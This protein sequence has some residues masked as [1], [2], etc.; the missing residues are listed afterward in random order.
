M[1]QKNAYLI[2]MIFLNLA[3]FGQRNLVQNGYRWR[4]DDASETAATWKAGN[5]EA[6]TFSNLENI[7]LRIAVANTATN[8]QENAGLVNCSGFQYSKDNLNWITI[9]ANEND[10]DFHL[11]YSEFANNDEATTQQ[12]SASSFTKGY[13]KSDY[14]PNG[15][16]INVLGSTTT[17]IEYCFAPNP[18]YD[19]TATYKFRIVGADSYEQLATVN[20][21]PNFCNI[22][23]PTV[24]DTY[25]VVGSTATPLVADGTNLL[26]YTTAT[27][28]KGS[29]TAPTP[30]TTTVGMT[31][32]W[33]S[34]TIGCESNRSKINVYVNGGI[35]A[36]HLN[37]DGENDFVNCDNDLTT[38]LNGSQ[39]LTVEA[40][41]NVS[42]VSGVKTI[43]SNHGTGSATQFCFRLIND[44]LDG[45]LGFG[46]YIATSAAGTIAPNTWY[47]VAM[48]YNQTSLKLYVNGT[49]VASNN[50]IPAGYG[51]VDSSSEIWM[52]GTGF[53]EFFKGDLDE[54]RVWNT[55]RTN[56]EINSNKNCDLTGNEAGLQSYYKFSDGDDA[57]DNSAASSLYDDSQN[58][59]YGT[60]TNFAL[61]GNTSN[62]LAGSPAGTPNSPIANAQSFCQNTNPTIENL[63]PAPSATTK[64]YYEETAGATAIPETTALTTRNYYVA[65]SNANGCESPKT[66]V[67]VIVKQT[68]A[69]DTN[70]GLQIYAGDTKTIADLQVV[71]TNISWYD[72]E[73]GG[74][75]LP[76]STLLTDGTRYYNSQN[77]N[78]CESMYRGNIWVKKVS[79]ATQSLSTGSTLADLSVSLISG[80]SARW[81]TTAT[82]GTPLNS[83][84]VL[85]SGTYFV[86]QYKEI[87]INNDRTTSSKVSV[88]K[89][90]TTNRVAVTVNISGSLGISTFD[91]NDFKL[92]P[93]P[94]K[95]VVTIATTENAKVLVYDLNGKKVLEKQITPTN[96]QIDLGNQNTG[97]YILNI[98]N[99]EG[100]AKTLKVIKE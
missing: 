15:S 21:N 11:A 75:S 3:M 96:N 71:G 66:L 12:I 90:F 30:Q 67:Y 92:Y 54:V 28:R 100:Q 26:W 76:T 16:F 68:Y 42:N 62:Y 84:D 45:F 13:F 7:R 86:E 5:N 14:N 63:V 24:F 31:N 79:N 41:I 89:V 65:T 29:S 47:H 48:V 70:W 49:E 83:T 39:K 61:S 44:K 40:W 85:N 22:T 55:A 56:E 69:P 19:K 34:Q 88:N 43:I 2:V 52:G 93:N 46:S 37:F 91:S 35:Q 82:G 38:L 95:D 23:K 20:P 78:G 10:G 4:T 6:I 81:Y 53:G 8:I 59:F 74:N 51:L 36:T 32:Y 18:S 99:Q 50:N 60:L 73:T 87:V 27:G 94:T 9:T 77:A 97:T 1:K 98:F 17:E 64:W 72:A 80:Y 25:Y 57:A 58:S 33:V